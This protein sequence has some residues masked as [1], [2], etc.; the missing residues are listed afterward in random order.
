MKATFHV[1]YQQYGFLELEGTT[2][3]LPEME[4]LQERYAERAV[5]FQTGEWKKIKTFTDEEIEYNAETHQYRSLEGKPLIGGST[6]AQQFESPFDKLRISEAYAIKHGMAQQ[7]VLDIWENNGKLS[8]LLGTT[9]HLAMENFFRHRNQ[10]AYNPPKSP[11]LERAVNACMIKG[12]TFYPE[13]MVSDI[14]SGR[15][16]QV[17]LL[18]ATGEKTGYIIDWKTDFSIKKNLKKHFQ[19][20]S[21]Y[22]H[23]LIAKGWTV[24]K[25]EVRN[26]TDTQW[27]VYESEVLPIVQ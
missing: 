12:E 22:A 26:F 16:G 10:P 5:K 23:I 25:V 9:L 13:I 7:D 4:K 6:Y 15:V 21:F 17:D 24:E 8:R 20:I 11:F 1:P 19:Q 27:D 14:S 3:D 18:V 2:K